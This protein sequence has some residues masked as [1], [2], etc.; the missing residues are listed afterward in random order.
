MSSFCS[1]KDAIP[2]EAF[3]KADPESAGVCPLVEGSLAG[4]LSGGIVATGV[5]F[6]DVD[7]EETDG[8]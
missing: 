4:C 1:G 6:R 3:V 8:S 2:A 7:D 5:G